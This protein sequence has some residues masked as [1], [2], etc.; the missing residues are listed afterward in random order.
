MKPFEKVM[1]SPYS[2][3]ITTNLYV[4]TDLYVKERTTTLT[5]LLIYASAREDSEMIHIINTSIVRLMC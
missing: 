1:G 4:D 2:P 5:I 3:L